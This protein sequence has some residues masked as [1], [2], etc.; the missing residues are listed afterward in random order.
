MLQLHTLPS[1]GGDTMFANMELAFATLSQT[2]QKFLCSLT[3]THA[4]EH[5]YRGR[6]ADRGVEDQDKDYP[7]NVHPGGAHPPGNRRLS[8]YVN[9]SFTTRINELAPQE[10]RALL[11]MLYKHQQRPEFRSASS[12]VKTTSL[13]GTTEAH[14]ILPC[15]ITFR[16]RVRDIA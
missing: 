4:S 7:E 1:S 16:R 14:N 13:S 15:G 9:P 6:Y 8:L 12:G 10:S 3:A 2:L 11:T 5:I